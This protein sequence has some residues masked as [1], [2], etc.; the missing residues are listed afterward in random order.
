MRI[1]FGRNSANALEI[2]D[3][4]DYY[5]FGM[6]HLKTGNAFYGKGSYQKYKYNG[7]E[8]QETGMYDYGARF[9]MPDLAR[10]GVV[11]PL[12]EKMT[13]HSPYNYGFDNPVRYTDPDGMAPEDVLETDCCPDSSLSRDEMEFASMIAGGINS[14]RASVSNLFARGYNE[15]AEKRIDRKYVVDEMGGLVLATGVPAE[16]GKEK[17][18][19]TIS[20]YCSIGCRRT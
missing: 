9:Y 14:V 7:K 3:A 17:I 10:W 4:N 1:S 18:Q 6:S 11:D 8:L 13:R 15:V 12:A 19:N 5:P 20:Y 2:T 16:T